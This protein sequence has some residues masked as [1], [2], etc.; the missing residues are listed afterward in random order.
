VRVQGLDEGGARSPELEERSRGFVHTKRFAV[1][2][3]ERKHPT[4][5]DARARIRKEVTMESQ[6]HLATDILLE[7][8]ADR[9]AQL[10]VD[11][12]R[13][14]DLGMIDQVNSP[15]GRRRHIAFVRNGG[16]IQI[17]RRY[18]ATKEA[19]EA[20]CK[21]LTDQTRKRRTKRDDEVR[22]LAKELGIELE[23]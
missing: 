17:G 11:K 1:V 20:H 18:L 21:V 12:L 5:F 10:V 4:T 23:E 22:A 7:K 8:M 2:S 16:G 9:V 14:G 19:I 13:A 15:L 6:H 3:R